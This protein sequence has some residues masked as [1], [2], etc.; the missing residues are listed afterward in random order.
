MTTKEQWLEKIFVSI[1][2]S[3]TGTRSNDDRCPKLAEAAAQ[4]LTDCGLSKPSED[5]T[6]ASLIVSHAPGR[7]LLGI[8]KE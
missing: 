4:V 1:I 6:Q 7:N 3:L 5:A 8:N 2:W